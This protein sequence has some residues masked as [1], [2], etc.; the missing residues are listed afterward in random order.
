MAE[1]KFHND[2]TTGSV[3]KQ[4]IRFSLPFL[5]SNIIQALYSV[6]DLIVVGHFSGTNSIT[7]VS[8]GGQINI[9]VTGIAFGLSV[10]GTIMVAQYAGAKRFADQR[11]TIGTMSFLYLILAAVFTVGMLLFGKYV[12]I[13]LRTP[14][15]AFPEALA[16]MNI[17]MMG[18]VFMFAYNVISSVLRG[19]GDSKRPLWFVSIA[20]VANVF[21]DVLLVRYFHM[22]AAG[23]A[24]AT[25]A[26]Q[27]L[28]VVLSLWYLF[29]QNFFAEYQ[30]R[31]FALDRTKAA[32]LIRIGFPSSIQQLVL[33]FSFLM[34]TSLVNSLP[35]ALVAAACQGIGGKL[36]AFAIMPFL[37]MSNAIA[38]MTGQNIGAG[39]HKRALRTVYV[40]IYINVAIAVLMFGIVQ[41]FPAQLFHIFTAD[42][43]V[44]ATGIPYLRYVSIDYLVVSASFCFGGLIIGSGYTKMALFNTVI[45]SIFLRVPLA[46]AFVYWLDMGLNGVGLAFG[47]ASFGTLL[48]GLWFVKSGRW[49]TPKIA[50]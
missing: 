34:L 18:T 42:P 12:L 3:P 17:C 27:A 39:E 16:Y 13:A 21:L 31:D 6:V 22:G 1:H 48:L 20:C 25:I 4:L 43:Q 35:N 5:L 47:I 33:N 19:M 26:S 37:A 29:R 9:L 28:S 7:G 40:G 41:L 36:N 8:I 32:Q 50:I 38:S 44:I 30:A 24:W 11:K 45:S 10:G 46:Y 23:A 49:K 15:E 2:L 14:E